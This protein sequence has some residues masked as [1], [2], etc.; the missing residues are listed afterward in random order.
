MIYTE[1]EPMDH[2]KSRYKN[3]DSPN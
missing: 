1:T 2:R 3:I